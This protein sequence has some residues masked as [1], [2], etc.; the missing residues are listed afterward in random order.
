MISVHDVSKTDSPDDHKNTD[1]QALE[2][3]SE[4]KLAMT[5]LSN[6][7]KHMEI[8]HNKCMNAGA[9]NCGILQKGTNCA[10]CCF[11]ELP[12]DDINTHTYFPHSSNI[13]FQCTNCAFNSTNNDTLEL[14]KETEHNKPSKSKFRNCQQ[15][16]IKR[17]HSVSEPVN[18][19]KN[20]SC[21]PE[22][23]DIDV[24]IETIEN[25]DCWH[26]SKTNKEIPVIEPIEDTAND[27]SVKRKI[28]LLTKRTPLN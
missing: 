5:E 9:Q 13:S 6:M 10:N 7:K 4:C 1:M 26:S 23:M 24:N 22:D 20:K 11:K 8:K 27:V 28:F 25:E 14:H 18:V 15:A 21:L 19:K 2:V 12:K 16:G 17:G 3:C